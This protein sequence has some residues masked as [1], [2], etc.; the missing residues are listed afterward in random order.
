MI[1]CAFLQ[2]RRLAQAERKKESTDFSRSLACRPDVTP[3]SISSFGRQLCGAHTAENE[4]VKSCSSIRQSS[5]GWT[6]QLNRVSST[7]SREL[8]QDAQFARALIY[9]A[10]RNCPPASC[11]L[12][13][14]SDARLRVHNHRIVAKRT[15]RA[16]GNKQ[17]PS[18]RPGSC[19]PRAASKRHSTMSVIRP[20]S[21]SVGDVESQR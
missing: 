9:L 20:S 11:P 15:S 18:A 6:R 3:S 19:K 21:A 1:A 12:C 4:S 13:L 5:T 16:T 2:H 7:V 8:E 14:T 17:H 10:R